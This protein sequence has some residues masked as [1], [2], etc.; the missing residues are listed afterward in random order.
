MQK[1]NELYQDANQGE[2]FDFEFTMEKQ[3][4]IE[5]AHDSQKWTATI[6]NS[7]EVMLQNRSF[8]LLTH[9]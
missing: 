7:S 8:I 6:A 3:I 4:Q 5:C 1:V 9:A 2:N